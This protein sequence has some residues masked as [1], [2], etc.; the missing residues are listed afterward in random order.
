M[1][2]EVE[3]RE[4]Q[5]RRGGFRPG[6]VLPLEMGLPLGLATLSKSPAALTDTSNQ[7]KTQCGF[8]HFYQN[9][10]SDTSRGGNDVESK[11]AVQQWL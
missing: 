6:S 9:C 4:K 10:K 2:G 11:A 3:E 8:V 7:Y 5:R 1:D